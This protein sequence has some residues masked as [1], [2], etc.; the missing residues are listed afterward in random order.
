[1]AGG[2]QDPD[3]EGKRLDGRGPACR[4]S[5]PRWETDAWTES[6]PDSPER[7]GDYVPGRPS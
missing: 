3:P 2:S 6:L 4:G 7:G 1:M 5:S